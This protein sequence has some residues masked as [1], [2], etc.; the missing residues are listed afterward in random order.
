VQLLRRFRR[1]FGPRDSLVGRAGSL[2]MRGELP[3]HRS[4][5]VGVK[6]LQRVRN[7]EVVAAAPCGAQGEVGDLA[8]LVVAEVVGVGPPLANDTAPSQLIEAVH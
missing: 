2:V 4:R 5:V 3:A 8:D 7:A 1:A 6:P